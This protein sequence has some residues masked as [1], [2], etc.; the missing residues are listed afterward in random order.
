[1]L[2]SVTCVDLA[3]VKLSD[4]SQRKKNIDITYMQNQKRGTDVLIYKTKVGKTY[5][6]Q[7]IM[8]KD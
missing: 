6:Y 8:G 2:F 5:S 1:M 3:V 4:D 7:G